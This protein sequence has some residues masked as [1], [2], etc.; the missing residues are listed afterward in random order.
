[1]EGQSSKGNADVMVGPW[2]CCD[3]FLLKNEPS[4]IALEKYIEFAHLSFN[5]QR[6]RTMFYTCTVMHSVSM[7]TVSHTRFSFYSES[8]SVM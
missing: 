3:S 5:R 1:M 7:L 2:N 6:C 4:I 8:L